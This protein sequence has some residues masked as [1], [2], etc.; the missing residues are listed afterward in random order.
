[1]ELDYKNYFTKEDLRVRGYNLEAEGV[2]DRSHF[3]T[4]EDAINDFMDNSFRA[5][6]NLFVQYRGRKWTNAFFEDMTEENLSG[7]ALDFKERLNRALVE[8]A[9][10]VYDNGDSNA[11][12]SYDERAARCGLAPKAVA[13]LWDILIW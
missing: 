11:N 6:Y 2:L 10:F 7:V 5:I 9:I 12:A 13:E 1:M 3:D 4:L 8:Q